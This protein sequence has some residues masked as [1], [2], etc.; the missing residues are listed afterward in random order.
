M[1]VAYVFAAGLVFFFVFFL[2]HISFPLPWEVDKW[3]GDLYYVEVEISQGWRGSF[4]C[5]SPKP[6][7]CQAIKCLCAALQ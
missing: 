5:A 4:N 3:G 6:A 1:G 7:S 2:F